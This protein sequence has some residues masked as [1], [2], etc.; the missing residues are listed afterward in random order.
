MK[1]QKV[2]LIILILLLSGCSVEM[3]S[4]DVANYEKTMENSSDLKEN[5]NSKVIKDKTIPSIN[6]HDNYEKLGSKTIKTEAIKTEAIKTEAIKTEATKAEATKTEA[7]KIEE[8]NIVNIYDTQEAV[9][10]DA[11][12]SGVTLAFSESRYKN[13]QWS[14]SPFEQK[15]SGEITND[16][17]EKNE[18]TDS[19]DY[20][21]SPE[22][23]E[24]EMI[25]NVQE[26]LNALG[27]EIGKPL[28]INNDETKTQVLQYQYELMT[29]LA[30]GDYKVE[31]DE[32]LYNHI[33]ESFTTVINGG[34]INKREYRLE[35][36]IEIETSRKENKMW[37]YLPISDDSNDVTKWKKIEVDPKYNYWIYDGSFNSVNYLG[38][39]LRIELAVVLAYCNEEVIDNIGTSIM[40]NSGYRSVEAQQELFARYWRDK[41]WGELYYESM[42]TIILMIDEGRKYRRIEDIDLGHEYKKLLDEPRILV[43]GV[44]K[45]IISRIMLPGISNHNDGRA[46]D[47]IINNS[48]DTIKEI[49]LKYGFT[50]YSE[51]KWHFDY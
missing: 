27:Y 1:I 43:N 14:T 34:Q 41:G 44:L 4:R 3:M 7:I 46:I 37:V 18:N 42:K 13:G 47:I 25:I 22:F 23:T 33:R 28:G 21:W 5:D 51:E 10:K 17:E 24:Y 36:R 50:E 38:D 30:Y 9:Y 31:M 2:L 39:E 29:N 16:I 8:I 11:M 49:L 48:Y 26:M 19:N 6:K 32:S 12:G 40:V 15:V 35:E 20:E 45:P